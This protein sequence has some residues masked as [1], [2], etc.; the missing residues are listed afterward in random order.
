M[1]AQK[2]FLAVISLTQI[3][4]LL[5][6]IGLWR[7]QSA[8]SLGGLKEHSERNNTLTQLPDWFDAPELLVGR[9]ISDLDSDPL[10]YKEEIASGF[11]FPDS[12]YAAITRHG[13]QSLT[14]ND[15][16]ITAVTHSSLSVTNAPRASGQI[17][18]IH[19]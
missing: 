12:R 3:V 7:N 9:K 16:L 19:E 15:G 13:I 18:N 2:T 4:T 6:V 8:T 10:I 11:S 14:L 17:S 1:N 5:L